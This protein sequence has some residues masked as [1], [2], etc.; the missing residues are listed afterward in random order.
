MDIELSFQLFDDDFNGRE[1]YYTKLSVVNWNISNI[2]RYLLGKPMFFSAELEKTDYKWDSLTPFVSE[3]YSD[4]FYCRVEHVLCDCCDPQHFVRVVETKD[5][6]GLDLVMPIEHL[7]LLDR[8]KILLGHF[9][10]DGFNPYSHFVE[11]IVP[12]S[13]TDKFKYKTIR[14]Y[15]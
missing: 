5:F 13:Q 3:E 7:P 6:E 12:K 4:T 1:L 10:L 9:F 14:G 2:F 11:Y 15:A 8:I